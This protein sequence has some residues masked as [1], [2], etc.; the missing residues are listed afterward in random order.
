MK[1]LKG[2]VRTFFTKPEYVFLLPALLFGLLS[3]FLMPQLIANDEN[4]H[5][6]RSYELSEL[7]TGHACTIPADIKD[8]GFYEMYATEKPNYG[9][10]NEKVDAD[11]QIQTDCGTATSYNPILHIPQTIGVTL[12]KLLWP[13]SGGMILLGRVLNVLVYCAGFFFIIKKT[14]IGKWPLVVIALLPMMIHMAGT[15]SGDIVNNLALIGFIVYGFN[16]FVQTSA[17]SKRQVIY[18]VLLSGLLAVAK[19]P[20]LAL[21]LMVLFLPKRVIP[22]FRIKGRMLPNVAVRLIIAS[23]CTFASLTVFI[24][25]TLLYDG[26]VVA[27]ANIVNPVSQDPSKFVSILVNTYI[28]PNVILGGV[29]YSDW[30]YRS[31]FGSFASFRYNLPY[32]LVTLLAMLFVVVSLRRDKAEDTLTKSSIKSLVAVTLVPLVIVIL[33][34]TYAL[35]SAWAIQSFALGEGATYALG[36]QGRYFTP[37]LLL[38]VP[39]LILVRRCV[40]V[41]IK[42][43][44]T[45]G[46]IVFTISTMV[47]SFYMM[48]TLSYTQALLG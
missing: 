19:P 40:S 23:I 33:A 47:L 9:F 25:W 17:M 11:Q 43:G 20:Y 6:I 27:S 4:M 15:L 21:L 5:F 44:I 3:A 38:L 14:K 13:T 30:L 1:K 16:L 39:V 42:T 24:G 8:R 34:I 48:Q 2:Y 41:E 18:L 7:E 35:Y 28:N 12:A 46:V 26:D 22:S 37:L 36:L 10:S 32:T 29:S 31:M 45:T